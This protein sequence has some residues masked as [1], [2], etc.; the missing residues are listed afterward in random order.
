MTWSDLV[1]SD[2]HEVR[3]G[4]LEAL[5]Y[6]VSATRV[7]QCGTALDAV[8]KTRFCKQR[9]CPGCSQQIAGR[10]ALKMKARIAAMKSPRYVLM[11]VRSAGLGAKN[12]KDAFG[13]LRHGVRRLRAYLGSAVPS[14][15]G[16]IEPRLSDD[17]KVVLVH[18]H[19]AIDVATPFDSG[20]ATKVWLLATT[21]NG[22][23]R[24]TIQWHGPVQSIAAFSIY[25]AKADDWSPPPGTRPLHVLKMLR[26]GT[27][28]RRLLIAWPLKTKFSG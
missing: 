15:V 8:R 23:V 16:A 19:L 5:G 11:S 1:S 27:R 28:G 12:I 22:A 17:G 4:E 20:V 14:G 9:L 24:G 10:N 6:H 13:L 21:L 26:E 7:R 18:T 3:A 25:G 2:P